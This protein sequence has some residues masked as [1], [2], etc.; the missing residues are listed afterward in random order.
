MEHS[1]AWLAGVWQRT[2]LTT[3]D[4]KRDNSTLVIWLQTQ[5]GLY[6]DLRIPQ[7]LHTE[8]AGAGPVTSQRERSNS[9]T[10]TDTNLGPNI[11]QKLPQ[12][13]HWMRLAEQEGFAGKIQ[14]CGDVCQWHREL[15][16][17]PAGSPPDVGRLSAGARE[18]IMIE[19]GDGYQ[20][21]T[22]L[23]LAGHTKAVS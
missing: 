7:N 21:V 23:A 22:M 13:E 9:L 14:L 17:Q 4:G 11:R 20:E 1:F 6:G 15:D 12:K 5:S 3:T 8:F 18:G 2:L 19:D 16:F 10:H